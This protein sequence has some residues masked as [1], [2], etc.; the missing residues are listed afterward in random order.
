M[1][2]EYRITFI[3]ETWRSLRATTLDEA[4]RELM[5][6]GPHTEEAQLRDADTGDI[7]PQTAPYGRNAGVRCDAC[8]GPCACGAWH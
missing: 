4:T 3:H 6:M 7:Y 2:L 8:T 5:A 1:K